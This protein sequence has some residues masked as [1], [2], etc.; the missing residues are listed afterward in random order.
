MVIN[1]VVDHGLIRSIEEEILPRLELR[2]PALAEPAPEALEASERPENSPS[3]RA[4]PRLVL[5]F[6]REGYRPDFFQRLLEK[7]IACLSYHKY[8][9]ANWPRVPEPGRDLG[10]WSSLLHA[11]GR[12]G[13]TSSQWA[14]AA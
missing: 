14:V 10:E 9:G 11:S 4:R 3:L 2:H 1:Q 8:P 6:D 7:R 13:H 12:T 5:V